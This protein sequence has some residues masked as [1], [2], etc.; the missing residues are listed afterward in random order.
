MDRSTG[1]RSILTF[2]CDHWVQFPYFCEHSINSEL[3]V[4]NFE[5]VYK[6]RAIANIDKTEPLET[7]ED[8]LYFVKNAGQV[9]GV[10]RLSEFYYQLG[11]FYARMALL[12]QKHLQIRQWL[13]SPRFQFMYQA[14]ELWLSPDTVLQIQRYEDFSDRIVYLKHAQARLELEKE[15]LISSQQ[16]RW[17]LS[18]TSYVSFYGFFKTKKKHWE[19]SLSIKIVSFL[20]PFN[21]ANRLKTLHLNDDDEF[22]IGQPAKKLKYHN[23]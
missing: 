12:H 7:K 3:F 17:I 9:D 16:R 23:K 5:R 13:L 18:L 6:C 19:K 21:K 20:F 15:K 14:P 10:D 1:D 8:I 2:I 22:C 11:D 4:L